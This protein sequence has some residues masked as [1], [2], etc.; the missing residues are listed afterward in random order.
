VSKLTLDLSDHRDCAS[1]Y[2]ESRACG[3]SAHRRRHLLRQR[4]W[5]VSSHRRCPRLRGQGRRI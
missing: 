1:G 4:R 3:T 5:H 2:L